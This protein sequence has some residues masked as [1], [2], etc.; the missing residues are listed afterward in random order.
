MLGVG[1]LNFHSG[2]F[3][4]TGFLLVPEERLNNKINK[5]E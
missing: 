1:E 4:H 5:I 3:W 2:Y